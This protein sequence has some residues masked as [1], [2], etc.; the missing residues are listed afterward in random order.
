MEDEQDKNLKKDDKKKGVKGNEQQMTLSW[1]KTQF[2]DEWKLTLQ[3]NVSVNWEDLHSYFQ[4]REV[5]E[6]EIKQIEGM[7]NTESKEA[8]NT[9]PTLNKLVE[10]VMK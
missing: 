6:D 5:K 8:L 9:P 4:E 7:E 2:K 1:V 3:Q 10:Q